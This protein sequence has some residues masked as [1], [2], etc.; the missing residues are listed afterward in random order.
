MAF[1]MRGT[2]SWLTLHP[3]SGGEKKN[4]PLSNWLNLSKN[5]KMRLGLDS[6]FVLG[7]AENGLAGEI[8]GQ[9]DNGVFLA[10]GLPLTDLAALLSLGLGFVGHD[11][12][13]THLASLLGIPTVALFGPT[14]PIHWSPLGQKVTVLAP[15]NG[16]TPSWR[17]LT[18][19]KVIRALEKILDPLENNP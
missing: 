14:N 8:R 2:K 10:E 16:P 4:W 11:S 6:L 3:G 15:K 9:S 7:P 13:V 17:W 18:E 12:G 1:E 19:E 5:L